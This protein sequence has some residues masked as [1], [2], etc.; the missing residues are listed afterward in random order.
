M[1]D[2]RCHTFGLTAPFP[3][4]IAPGETVKYAFKM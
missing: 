3:F 1:W 4:R 2:L